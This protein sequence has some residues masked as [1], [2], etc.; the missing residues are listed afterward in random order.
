LRLLVAAVATI[1]IVA[2]Y[3]AQ[4]AVEDD[5]RDGD[6][7]FEDNDYKRA[8]A[9]YDRAISKAPGQ[10]SPEAYAKRAAIFIIQKD[11]KG[12]LDFVARAKQRYPSSPAIQEQE[13]LMLWQAGQKEKA[14]EVAE[15]VVKAAPTAFSNQLL[16]GEYYAGRDPVKTATAFEAYLANR[17]DERAG[18]DVL[19]RIRL[20]FAYLSNARSV[21][22]DGDEDR[23]KTL[24][25]KAVDQF[26]YVEHKLGK[27]P[28]AMVNAENG[29][30][31]AYAGL[32]R[33][34]QAINVCERVIQD[35]RRVDTT[36]SAWFNLG[37]AYLA[38][39][40]TKKARTAGNE[41]T[42]MRK[43]EARGYML[44]GQTYFEDRDWGNAL[45]QFLRA[46]KTLKPNQ[47]REQVQLSIWLGKTYRRLPA[48]STGN[49]PN[50]AL[51]I[52]K[53]SG[54]YNANPGSVELAAEL[55]GAYLEA[56]QDGKA[57][58]LTDNLMSKP[59]F[60]KAPAVQRANIMLI[61]GKALFNQK[62]L[63]E[64]RQ[65]FESA[66]T[67]RPNDVSVSRALVTTINEQAAAEKDPKDAQALLNQALAIDAN[68][69]VTLTNMAIL[70]IERGDCDGAQ[71]QLVRLKDVR[72]TDPVLT[73]RLLAR[74]YMC[75]SKPDPKKASEA[76]AVAEREAKRSNASALAEIYTEWAPLTWDTDL[77]GAVDKLEQAVN[78]AAQD[79]DVAPAAKRNLALALYRRGWKAMRDGRAGDAASDFDRALRDPSVLKG[80]EPVAFE[81]SSAL[82]ELDSGRSSDAARQ[83]KALAA[84]GNQASYLRGAYAKV[85]GAFFSAY[86]G[87]RSGQGRAREQ[88]CADLGKFEGDLGN[89]A[90]ELTASCWEMVAAD[91]WRSG[92]WG[93]AMKSLQS[94]E[95]LATADQKR[96]LTNDRA[97][98]SL[99]KDKID[100]LEALAGNPAEALV[101]LGIIYDMLGKP[102]EAYDAWSR[103]KARGVNTRDLQ[104]WIDAKKRIYGY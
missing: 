50:L 97:A 37:H 20:G 103:A 47:T 78:F 21:L 70:A 86:A 33:W 59:D 65:R 74:A 69:P 13:A 7:Y 18:L 83:F 29:L 40:Q 43:N 31:A 2:P 60:A 72:A 100:D 23:A 6:K 9:S 76:Y 95:R 75:G 27:K 58:V 46:E 90:R 42:R 80:N 52:E 36:G 32:G 44:L 57:G 98:L 88:A 67:L 104:K 28:N 49:N 5:L 101:N 68:S 87:Y 12:G 51:A 54:A 92:Q 34:D 35:P 26:E 45:D 24:Y 71:K 16:I 22:G 63:K 55:G 94:A 61:S 66:R 96:R 102:R 79:P 73:P 15:K 48:P 30:C 53:L 84:K 91:Q 41:F 38:R 3:V 39:K 19:P 8:A 56:K 17:P 10:V 81:F 64:A 11:I 4:A 82:A 93:A 25:T 99:G 14:I 85:G 62:K 1:A 77:P 89:R